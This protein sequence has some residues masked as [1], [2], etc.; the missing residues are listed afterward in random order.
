MKPP[1]KSMQ[2]LAGL[3]SGAFYICENLPAVLSVPFEYSLRRPPQCEIKEESTSAVGHLRLHE[4]MFNHL[5]QEILSLLSSGVSF[6][7]KSFPPVSFHPNY[8]G[9]MVPILTSLFF[10]YSMIHMQ[11]SR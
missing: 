4:L 7:R 2:D 5:T 9:Q 11:R 6:L 3:L 8:K 10:S 1:E